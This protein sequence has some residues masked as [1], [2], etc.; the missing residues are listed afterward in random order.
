MADVAHIILLF[1]WLSDPHIY[2][3]LFKI[4]STKEMFGG[5]MIKSVAC[6]MSDDSSNTIGTKVIGGLSGGLVHE[7]NI[8]RCNN[9]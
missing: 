1:R 8:V 5:E 7:K 9:K 3:I 2:P 4:K 6:L